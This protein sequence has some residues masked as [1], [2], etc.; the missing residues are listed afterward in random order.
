MSNNDQE[1]NTRRRHR[2]GIFWPLALI[3]L[4]VVFLL[5]SMG[6]IQGSGWDTFF[7]LWPILLILISLDGFFNRR[8]FA[9]NT[10]VLVAGVLFLLSNF[11][12]ISISV[13]NMILYLWPLL[14]VA[15]GFDLITRHSHWWVKLI[16][17][18]AFVLI[19]AGVLSYV[20][21]GLTQG[22]IIATTEISQ[23]LGGAT[24]GEVSIEPIATELKID[25]NAQP[26]ML[27]SGTIPQ[28]NQIFENYSLV[29][30]KANYRIWQS[31]P[32]VVIPP[33]SPARGSWMLEITREIPLSLTVKMVV[34][35]V[36]QELGGLN[37]NRLDV[38]SVIS[39]VQISLPE[40]GSFTGKISNVMG[41][42]VVQV[43]EQMEVRIVD[44]TALSAV[45]VPE[46][47]T[48]VGD[49]YTSPGYDTAENQAD[50][51]ISSVL[52]RIEITE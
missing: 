3:I 13:W 42:I 30:G 39:S 4:G 1:N 10:L 9:A 51:T 25:D 41:N 49:V 16:G 28:N 35:N 14:I 6:I 43:P 48:R 32:E 7:S 21:A 23:S 12:Y 52:G 5:S 29:Q 36:S 15:F 50:L 47:F 38:E 31:S 44:D 46:D 19:L 34:G 20:G 37:L 22:Q 40:Q 27:I 17:L 26:G 33:I 24:S 8:D 2:P 11:G 18:A 45:S